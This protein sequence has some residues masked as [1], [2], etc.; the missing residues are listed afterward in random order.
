M[1]YDRQHLSIDWLFRDVS[2][3]EIAITGLSMSST[4]GWSGAAAALAEVDADG[5]LPGDLMVV[6]NTLMSTGILQ[7]A[8]YSKLHGIKIA[9]IGT[10]GLYLTEP[11]IFETVA[12]FQGVAAAT[13][14]QLTVVGSLRS[15]SMLGRA[16]Y[17]RMYLPHTRLPMDTGGSVATLASATTAVNAFA[18]FI[19]GVSSRVNL[20][21]TDAVAPYIMTNTA[22]SP[23][24][25]VTEV[26]VGTV[27]DTQRRRREQLTESYATLSL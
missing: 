21:L 27:T 20:T 25:Q 4:L 14:P 8:D 1:A 18:A 3:D 22:P 16:N 11:V 9:A 5:T 17:G 2:S 7:W 12:S 19:N 10:D 23:S 15:G 13:L 26:R 6:A 24:K